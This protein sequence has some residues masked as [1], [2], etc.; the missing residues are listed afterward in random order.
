MRVLGGL[1][2]QNHNLV[3]FYEEG[4]VTNNFEMR[5]NDYLANSKLNDLEIQLKEIGLL[6]G[7]FHTLMNENV[8]PPIP[9]K[10]NE[11]LKRLEHVTSSNT[12]WRAPHSKFTE[13]ILT[14]GNLSLDKIIL[15]SDNKWKLIG[16]EG[17][18][19]QT[20]I[21]STTRF[22]AIRDLASIYWSI[23]KIMNDLEIY[24]NELEKNIRMWLFESWL[25]EAPKKWSNSK[26]LDTHKGGIMI[27]EYDCALYELFTEQAFEGKN[28][29]HTK[30][31]L[32]NVTRIQAIMFKNRLYSALSKISIAI[33]L[34]L[35]VGWNSIDQSLIFLGIFTA[36][37]MSWVFDRIYNF[38]APNHWSD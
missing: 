10:W 24:D 5:I 31:W 4:I 23:S 17:M 1:K 28:K 35:L 29:I 9:E 32:S 8:A 21:D 11:R 18:K 14:H 22:P 6:L 27:W 12:L 34:L 15:D 3:T 19:L 33:G 13:A 30:K 20:L 2:Y 25:S 38:R 36:F 16:F 26:S 37:L 7:K